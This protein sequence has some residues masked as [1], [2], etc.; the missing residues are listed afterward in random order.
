MSTWP[1]VVKSVSCAQGARNIFSLS[2][3]V[4]EKNFNLYR[5]D[6]LEISAEKLHNSCVKLSPLSLVVSRRFRPPNFLLCSS[7]LHLSTRLGSAV[8]LMLIMN[9]HNFRFLFWWHDLKILLTICILIGI[10]QQT[11]QWTRW[12]RTVEPTVPDGCSVSPISSSL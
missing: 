11:I 8:L 12:W 3:V 5:R 9:I 4:F 1:D 6:I 2:P 7:L 10:C